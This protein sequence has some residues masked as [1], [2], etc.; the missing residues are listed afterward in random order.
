MGGFL[1]LQLHLLANGGT[2]LE[3]DAAKADRHGRPLR[4][5]FFGPDGEFLGRGDARPSRAM[6]A[7][8]PKAVSKSGVSKAS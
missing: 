5:Y 4:H 7:E 2:T 3:G 1:L 6:A 8:R